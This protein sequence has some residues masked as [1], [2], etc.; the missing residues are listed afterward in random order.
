MS[1]FWVEASALALALSIPGASEAQSGAAI[2]AEPINAAER[3]QGTAATADITAEYGG[4]YRGSQAQ[5]AE[6]VGRRIAVQSGLSSDPSAFNVTLLNSSV[7]NAFA[8]PGGYVYVTRNLLALMNDEAELAAVLGHEVGHVAARHSAKREKTATRN[9]ILGALGQL[10]VGSVAGNSQVGQL[11]TRGIGTGA[12]LATLGFSRSQETQ[13]DD[14]GINYLAGAGY[15]PAALSTMLEDLAAQNALT[16]QIAG[17]SS[18]R[19]AWAST[20]PDPASR[21]RRAQQ[22]AAQVSRATGERGRAPF[23]AAIDG[24]LYGDDP[25]QGVIDGRNFLY[26]PGR[27][28]FSVPQGFAIANGARAV[29]ISGDDGQAQFSTAPYDGDLPRYVTRV[30]SQL[31]NISASSDAVRQTQV[32]GIPAAYTTVRAQSG[33]TE[34]DATVFAYAPS[35][36]R[37]YHF[38][39]LAPAGQGLGQLESLVASFRAMTSADTAAARPRYLRVVAVRSGDTQETLAARMAFSAYRLERF[40]VL[41]RLNPGQA[42]RPGDKVKIVTY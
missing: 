17:A 35:R 38:L 12:Q 10:L 28:A 32:N 6:R 33:Q 25:K 11:L 40:R 39:V 24:M 15:D 9:S 41:N 20:H 1:K 22:Q 34:I 8:I 36:D 18:A 30:L 16:Q 14:L 4:V 23:L 7:D 42:M 31:G 29:T 5:Y 13:A 3:Q 27:V 21:V 26:A 2:Q 19:P 37:A